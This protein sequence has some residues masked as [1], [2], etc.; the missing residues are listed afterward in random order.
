[1]GN[2]LRDKQINL[3]IKIIMLFSVILM[4]FIIFI[5]IAY[6]IMKSDIEEETATGLRDATANTLRL[7]RHA[8]DVSIQNY[9]R[10]IAEKN[11]EIVQHFDQMIQNGEISRE[12][13]MK[14]LREVLLSQKIGDTGYI[15]VW[16]IS[17]SPDSITLAVHPQMEG[18]DVSSFDFVQRACQMRQGYM[19]YEWK[20]PDDEH[21]RSKSM[22]L[23]YYEPW[24]WVIAVSTYRDEFHKLINMQDIRSF[25]LSQHFGKTGYSFILDYDGRMVVHPYI[26]GV[27]LDRLDYTGFPITRH[28]LE[29][30]EG[31]VEYLWKHE[32]ETKPRWKFAY[33][34]EY[35]EMN[36]IVVSTGYQYEFFRQLHILGY[37]LMIPIGASLVI[38]IAFYIWSSRTIIHPIRELEAAF[39]KGSNGDL[40]VRVPII[41]NNEIYLLAG[42]FNSFMKSLQ[43]SHEAIQEESR[44]LKIA[45]A[46]SKA[47]SE[48][49]DNIV[50]SLDSCLITVHAD[51]NITQWNQA[52][53]DFTGISRE[54]AIGKNY[55]EC[56]PFLGEISKEF[57]Q[58]LNSN[59]HRS[60]VIQAFCGDK[61]RYLH[62][63]FNPLLFNGSRGIVLRID[64]ITEDRI[65]DRQLLQAQKMEV[66][67]NLAGGLAHDFNN[68]L[69][70]VT[71]TITLIEYEMSKNMIDKKNLT[72]YVNII[73]QSTNRAKE[74]VEQ[75]LT[76]SQKRE[77]NF[78]EHDLR[79]LIDNVLQI[80]Y[81]T[82]DKSIE[83]KTEFPDAKTICKAEATQIEQALLNL[84]INASHAMT[85]MRDPTEKHGGVL[86]ISIKEVNADSIFLETH[87]EAQP[88]KYWCISI[89]DTGVGMDTNTVSK[90]FE[91][92][93]SKKKQIKGTGLGLSMVYTIIRQHGGFIDIYSEI[94]V[95]TV[96]NIFIPVATDQVDG[97][98]EE[99]V[100]KGPLKKG[101]GTILVIDDNDII[102]ATAR[103]ILRACGYTV[104]LAEDGEIGVEVYKQRQHEI[105]AIISDM[106]MPN[107]SGKEAYFAIKKINPDAR[108]AIA[109][110]YRMDRRVQEVMESG[111]ELFIQKPYTLKEMSDAAYELTAGPE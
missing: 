105:D 100:Q 63:N 86:S 90:I 94:G 18:H 27:V 47:A 108:I 62:I 4:L 22:Y 2:R 70:G 31:F 68:I 42:Y 85:I 9:L 69:G 25:V 67:G 79:E 96:F 15:F 80:C 104:I 87:P 103:D 16:D 51:G 109:S 38:F 46:S 71:G 57:E 60:I 50:N 83:I 21:E 29:N 43:E 11:L 72:R 23:S 93:F 91:P 30:R 41:K 77:I 12:Q 66:I 107:M 65:K 99:V 82:F 74:V 45:E 10:A 97:K 106:V 36:W 59:R 54:H 92:F 101:T 88:I 98:K 40:S 49:L 102:R 84:F 33:F 111:A 14:Q 61:E 75:L 5:A 78:K 13:G 26:Q 81:T 20:N 1:M 56:L 89:G 19:E 58:V 35:P 6:F 53:I 28:I 8:V 3:N 7:T 17:K 73:N 37:L 48:Y 64:D 110:G 44:K 52:V 24:N 95:G 39:E 34:S 55:A 76:I 32:N